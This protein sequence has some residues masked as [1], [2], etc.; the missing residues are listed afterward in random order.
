MIEAVRESPTALA[1]V[2]QLFNEIQN[3]I[4]T[5]KGSK[6]EWYV[7]V[8]SIVHEALIGANLLAVVKVVG[9]SRMTSVTMMGVLPEEM[10]NATTS[11]LLRKTP[12]V[13][14]CHGCCKNHPQVTALTT[15]NL[16]RHWRIEKSE[17]RTERIS[18]IATD[19][20]RVLRAVMFI[21]PNF[22]AYSV[23]YCS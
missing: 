14:Q 3:T 6:R 4:V 10:N 18:G 9:Q 7:P 16:R 2:Q 15:G 8:L 11:H 21:I 12:T 1:R 20:F 23:L 13:N 19:P 17:Q 5:V 22:R